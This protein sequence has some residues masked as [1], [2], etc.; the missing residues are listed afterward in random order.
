[1]GI[2][3][4]SEKQDPMTSHFQSENVLIFEFCILYSL[5]AA[6]QKAMI[7]PE[8]SLLNPEKTW[9]FSYFPHLLCATA[10]SISLTSANQ[11]LSFA[12]GNR[13]NI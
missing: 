3:N 13:D 2:P 11:H 8:P 12:E 6:S 1:M 4:L 5:S 9:G 7:P 10:T